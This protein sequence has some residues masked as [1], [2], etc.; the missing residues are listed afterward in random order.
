MLSIADVLS[1][2]ESVA[3]TELY[4]KIMELHSLPDYPPVRTAYQVHRNAG[5]VES[6]KVGK[7]WWTM[8]VQP[9]MDECVASALVDRTREDE[10]PRPLRIGEGHRVNRETWKGFMQKVTAGELDVVFVPASSPVV[11][12]KDKETGK[13]VKVEYGRQQA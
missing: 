11:A 9:D 8:A 2:V 5:R 1:E 13:T 12:Y 7:K 3:I 4:S 10:Q 6:F